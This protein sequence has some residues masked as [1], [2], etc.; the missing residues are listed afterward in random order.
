MM[1]R[2][3]PVPLVRPPRLPDGSPASLAHGFR[4][5]AALVAQLSVNSTTTQGTLIDVPQYS[6]DSDG[7][8]TE[9]D[10]PTLSFHG[11]QVTDPA[12]AGRP[13]DLRVTDPA[14]GCRP[15][16]LDAA[17]PIRT[18]EPVLVV[19]LP[20]DPVVAAAEQQITGSIWHGAPTA[21]LI[22]GG[23][24]TLALPP[25][26]FFLVL[27]VRRRQWRP[28]KELI[29]QVRGASPVLQDSVGEVAFGW[30]SS[31]VTLPGRGGLGARCG[32]CRAGC[33]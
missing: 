25:L 14:I 15:L 4:D 6:T 10:V 3:P 8:T 33:R 31:W 2:S 12:M 23:L 13:L 7:N 29:D 22:S 5:A 32:W 30:F 19:Y 1:R 24:F 16:A 9:T 26:L 18:D 17:N 27:W 28:A 21:N 20:S 11:L